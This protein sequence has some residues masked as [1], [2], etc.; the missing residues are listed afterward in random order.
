MCTVLFRKSFVLH[1]I[2]DLKFRGQMLSIQSHYTLVVG[3]AIFIELK[4]GFELVLSRAGFEP[5]QAICTENK[6]LDR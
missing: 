5:V 2:Y 6:N 3:R 4:L 1:L